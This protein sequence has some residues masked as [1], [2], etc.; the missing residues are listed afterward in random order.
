MSLTHDFG[1][2]DSAEQTDNLAIQAALTEANNYDVASG[3]LGAFGFIGAIFARAKANR[4]LDKYE[5][6]W[7]PFV[8]NQVSQP[9][10]SE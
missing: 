1:V 9:D 4:L 2:G 5:R 6:T 3:S 8:P 7:G 10:A